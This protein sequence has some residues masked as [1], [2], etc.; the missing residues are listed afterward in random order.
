M[1]IIA[2]KNLYYFLK[3]TIL[4]ILVFTIISSMIL[5]LLG[6]ARSVPNIQFQFYRE[7]RGDVSITL[8]NEESDKKIKNQF[9]DIYSIIEK[10]INLP[11][12]TDIYS[13]TTISGI[14]DSDNGSDVIFI[15]GI[16]LQNENYMQKWNVLSKGEYFSEI[17]DNTIILDSFI[18]ETMDL[19]IGDQVR[20]SVFS[21]DGIVNT[22]SFIISGFF[23]HSYYSSVISSTAMQTLFDSSDTTFIKIFTEKGKYLSVKKDV[24]EALKFYNDL[25]IEAITVN[26]ELKGSSIVRFFNAFFLMLTVIMFLFSGILV[27]VIT[28]INLFMRI[29][30]YGT[31]IAIGWQ[32]KH[33]FLLANLEYT[34]IALTSGIIG[35]LLGYILGI[36]LN[37]LNLF[38]SF[39]NFITGY[40]KPVFMMQDV[41]LIIFL[42]ILSFI[43]WTSVSVN[44][45]MKMGTIKM[46]NYI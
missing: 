40:I 38:I 32:P 9:M 41:F 24:Q 39:G 35:S 12:I 46:L 36:I 31:C 4:L 20:I 34:Y 16:D 5:L 43:F 14:I 6:I 30:E 27:G 28:N 19:Q 11:Y 10:L 7:T 26:E 3:S 44:Y 22:K 45:I 18:H 23:S 17:Y 21:E 33:I 29:R 1:I 13:Y 2:F 37:K 8:L 42:L 15:T 25:N